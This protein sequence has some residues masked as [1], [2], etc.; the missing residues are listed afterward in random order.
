[1][2]L[3]N[4]AFLALVQGDEPAYEAALAEARRLA[5]AHGDDHA[6]AY[7][8]HVEGYHALI[9]NDM[10]V[11]VE[12]FG[13]SAK[14][15]RALGDV[16][17]ELWSTYNY[18]I[19]LAINGDVDRGQA[20]LRECIDEYAARG[21]LF[22]QCW[23]L[24]SLGAAEY[25]AGDLTA[26]RSHCEEVLRRQVALR[27]RAIIAFALEVLAGVAARA[28]YARRAA[29][30]HGAAATVWH[31][32]GTSPDR[33]GA[34]APELE[35]DVAEVTGRLG[36][37]AAA[38]E[39][40]AGAEMTLTDALDFALS[41]WTEQV[42]DEEEN[43]LTVRE[44]QVA[45]L[46]AQGMTNREIAAELDIAQRTAETHVEHILTKLGFSNRSRVAAWVTERRGAPASST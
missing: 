18:G 7:V 39:F 41:D 24:W 31:S 21:E 34:F 6:A 8:Q 45:A 13:H 46:V 30:L 14:T 2:L 23:A 15:L 35:R 38:D 40:A 5:E 32:L 1:M 3:W 33:Y 36:W 27:D 12:R 10:P 29:R 9:G 22:W 42:Q 43:P 11:A 20:V 17:G 19:A 16:G 4:Y 37:D 26:A 28:R 44:Q 25:L